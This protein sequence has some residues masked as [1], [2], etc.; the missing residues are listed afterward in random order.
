VKLIKN[1]CPLDKIAQGIHCSKTKCTDL[2]KNVMGAFNQE[3]LF[4]LLR[5]QK[6]S[7]VIDKS[8]DK[9]TTKHLF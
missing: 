5:Q 7:L 3:K 4:S 9:S 2:V 6:F 1:I 8:T